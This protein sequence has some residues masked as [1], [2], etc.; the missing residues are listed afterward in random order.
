MK[1][2]VIAAILGGL[3]IAL[4]AVFVFGIVKEDRK[5]PKISLT[6]KNQLVYHEGDE[7]AVLLADVT[8]EDETD[9]D[10][11][12]SVRVSSVYRT[13]DDRAVVVYAAKDDANN[14]GRMMRE[15]KYV[16]AE[17]KDTDT[18]EKT[19]EAQTEPEDVT[20]EA[21]TD[22]PPD[23]ENTEPDNTEANAGTPVIRLVQNAATVKVGESFNALRY[24]LSATDADGND[25]SRN[26]HIDGNYDLNTPGV[27][28]LSIYAADAGGVRTN[29]ETFTLTVEPAEG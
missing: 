6:G 5:A 8:A 13:A 16:A 10:V 27:Y 18:S 26:I 14:I 1:K 28:T 23:E 17:P 11:T 29:V 12:D 25:L 2:S 4:S 7:D 20:Q 15:V 19:D 3:C 24:V 9:G 22:T 21:G